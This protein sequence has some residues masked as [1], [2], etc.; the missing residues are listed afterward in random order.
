ME[1]KS[2][3]ASLSSIVSEMG[4]T[5]KGGS[6]GQVEQAT[7][8]INANQPDSQSAPG[9]PA[10]EMKSL[11]ASFAVDENKKVVIRIT[12]EKGNLIRQIPPEEY[13]EMAEAL[14]ESG[15][16]LFHLEA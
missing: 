8:R 1:I 2:I 6:D 13:L 9:P 14:S 12:D 5:E 10:F 7:A 4:R 16:T 15:K 11:K 3:D